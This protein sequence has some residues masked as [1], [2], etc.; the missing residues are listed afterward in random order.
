MTF[1]WLPTGRCLLIESESSKW[2]LGF[3]LWDFIVARERKSDADWR[4]WSLREFLGL[5]DIE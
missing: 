4:C 3:E 2:W 1:R 5:G